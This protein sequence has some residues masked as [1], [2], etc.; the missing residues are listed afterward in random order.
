MVYAD[1]RALS[2]LNGR[3]QHSTNMLGMKYGDVNANVALRS[4]ITAFEKVRPHFA[5]LS[6]GFPLSPAVSLVCRSEFN[7]PPT[8]P[9]CSPNCSVCL[10]QSCTRLHHPAFNAAVL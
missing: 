1:F 10:G 8:H 2:N 4:T 6:L 3:L 9:A 5:A 7:P